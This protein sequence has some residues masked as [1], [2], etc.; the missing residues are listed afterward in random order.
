MWVGLDQA[1]TGR[2][3]EPKGATDGD[4]G[5]AAA[6]IASF[7]EQAGDPV[8]RPSHAP[9]EN[10]RRVGA[11]PHDELMLEL[12]VPERSALVLGVRVRRL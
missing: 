7:H 9:V 5:H 2:G 11:T 6:P 1:A 4:G 8:V 10:Q 12:A 3:D